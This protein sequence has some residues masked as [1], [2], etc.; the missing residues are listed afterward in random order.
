[1]T[2]RDP[3]I[4]RRVVQLL[5]EADAI[6][7]KG[8]TAG[9]PRLFGYGYGHIAELAG[10]SV[11]AARDAAAD[12]QYDPADMR[13]VVRWADGKRESVRVA[14]LLAPGKRAGAG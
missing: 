13:D 4:E 3:I 8:P 9:R 6:E 10:C 2:A 1:M 5:S 14:G 7:G 11:A 12:G